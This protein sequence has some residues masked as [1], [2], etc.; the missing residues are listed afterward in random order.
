MMKSARNGWYSFIHIKNIIFTDF[1]LGIEKNVG[2]VWNFYFFFLI[3]P[4]MKMRMKKIILRYLLCAM[5]IMGLPAAGMAAIEIIDQEPTAITITQTTNNI[6]HVTN[7]SGQV[8][9]IYNVAGKCIKTFKV[10]GADRQ[11]EI[12]LP[13]GIYIVKVGETARR[14]MVK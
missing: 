5:M 4:Q 6:L 10:E 2:K 8:L 12:N 13:K 9:R 14:I 11:Y 3:L 7:A 1:C